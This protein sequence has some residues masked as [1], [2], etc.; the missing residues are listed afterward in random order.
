MLGSPTENQMYLWNGETIS[1]M[2]MSSK[3]V[4]SAV[5]SGN[6]FNWFISGYDGNLYTIYYD[7]T[8]YNKN[9]LNDYKVYT[10]ADFNIH[11]FWSTTSISTNNHIAGPIGLWIGVFDITTKRLVFTEKNTNIEWCDFSPDG[12]YAYNTL[13]TGYADEVI[14]SIFQITETGINKIGVL[15]RCKYTQKIW[16]PGYD[17]KLLLLAG[18]E[19]A[20]AGGSEENTVKIVDVAVVK[21]EREFQVK[22]GHLTNLDNY[23]KQMAFWDQNPFTDDKRKLYIYNYESGELVK[24]L[25]LS[26]RMDQFYI[27]RSRVISNQGFCLDYSNI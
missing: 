25:N 6:F 7:L 4:V 13:Y 1:K 19:N 23:T 2:D 11:S 9:N 21:I 27:F 18:Y 12:K 26:P 20:S 24:E 22:V 17:H 5:S 14:I 10:T 8:R 16:M 15:P 3:K